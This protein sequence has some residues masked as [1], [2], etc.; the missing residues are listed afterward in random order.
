MFTK[1][2]NLTGIYELEQL[3]II[4]IKEMTVILLDA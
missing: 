1:C 2:I 3:D 4:Q